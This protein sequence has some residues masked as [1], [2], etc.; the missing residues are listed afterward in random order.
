MGLGAQV[1]VDGLPISAVAL[2]DS[3]G[4][5]V[6]SRLPGIPVNF[7]ANLLGY[8][9]Q[10]MANP[11]L[12]SGF[13]TPSYSSNNPTERRLA[14]RFRPMPGVPV[15]A[16]AT[17][18]FSNFGQQTNPVVLTLTPRTDLGTNLQVLAAPPSGFAPLS[19]LLTLTGPSNQMPAGSTV[20][21]TFGDGTA[22]NGVNLRSLTHTYTQISTN[23]YVV[24]AQVGSSSASC[25]VISLP[26][27][28]STPNTFN[29]F[30]AHF[31]A[32]GTIPANFVVGGSNNVSQPPSWADLI[33][34]QQADCASFDMDHA[35]PTTSANRNYS[36][37]GFTFVNSADNDNGFK[38]EDFNYFIT[39]EAQW[40]DAATYGY[41]INDDLYDPW[42]KTAERT[43][44]A[45]PRFRMTCNLSPVILPPPNAEVM[46]V[47]T[48]GP[49][50]VFYP[51]TPDPLLDV[52][53]RQ[54][55]QIR[56]VQ[57]ITGPL[58][59]YWKGG[60]P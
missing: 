20:A 15:P 2:A 1:L 21:W 51:E 11:G 36:Q 37:D 60:A 31:T 46:A 28:G 22:T 41:S 26:S 56:G 39:D 59:E 53:K 49:P 7:T 38:A 19:V 4:R 5:F 29:F 8:S 27:P 55:A 48:N 25:L 33:M 50:P 47:P 23:G 16:G 57:L 3:N 58:A 35:P 32:G 34:V 6:F 40:E 10:D 52:L 12:S 14:S 30:Q 24:S 43:L 13:T 17:S 45:P 42:P 54:I 44:G 18:G 9:P